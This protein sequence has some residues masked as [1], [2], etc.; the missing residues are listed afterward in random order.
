MPS[1]KGIFLTQGSNPHL[2]HLLLWQAGSLPLAPPGTS[3]SSSQQSDESNLVPAL[4]TV[5]Q[6][7]KPMHVALS[8]RLILIREPG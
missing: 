6:T 3:V 1:S 8:A 5:I 2:L 7:R 4:T